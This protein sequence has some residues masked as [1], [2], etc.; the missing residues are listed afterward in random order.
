M[1]N[2]SENDKK[3]AIYLNQYASTAILNLFANS[4]LATQKAA[5]E[6]ISPDRIASATA[7]SQFTALSIAN[8]LTQ[9]LLNSYN[10]QQGSQLSYIQENTFD[11]DS[12]VADNFNEN[13][14]VA[15]GSKPSKQNK[16]T[17]ASN[18]KF[19]VWVNGFGQY[20]YDNPKHQTPAFNA[21]S[22]GFVSGC[23]Y[24]VQ[25]LYPIGAGVAYAYSSLSHENHMGKGKINQGS[26]FTYGRFDY[27]DFYWNIALLGGYY[28]VNNNR[29]ISFPGYHK[30]AHSSTNGWQFT[31]HVE[32]GYNYAR[33][34][35]IITPF[36]TL[37]DVS[38]WERGFT[39]QGADLL[40]MS[41]KGRYCNL[42]RAE[43]GLR[44]LETIIVKY[45]K[46]SF[47]EK[48]SYGYQKAFGTGSITAFL[49]GSS[50]SFGLTAFS[51]AQNLGIGELAFIFEPNNKRC[52]L[53]T[54]NFEATAG[55]TFQSYLG[56]CEFAWRF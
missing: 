45:G 40:N 35:A 36:I 9:N 43:S 10:Q 3:V 54:L 7:T 37:D 24:L 51:N 5:L 52:P 29:N 56:S 12:L 1:D 18:P 32:F 11:Q 21:A 26:I 47:L 33:S 4:S 48:I 34:F 23:D 30:T 55:S 25:N 22:G 28:H 46:L 15:L 42:L 13:S 20:I 50:G 17:N 41:V 44:F 14:L 8:A 6:S 39:E 31:P 2:F 38:N 53:T 19:N 16:K 27:H 49:A